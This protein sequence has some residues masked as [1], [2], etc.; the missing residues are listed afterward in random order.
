MKLQALKILVVTMGL[1]IFIGLGFLAYGLAAK[2]GGAS[3]GG[4]SPLQAPLNVTLP[5]GAEVTETVLGENRLLVR[6]TLPDG[7]TRLMVFN[8]EDG[9][10]T[11]IINL[12][13]T[14]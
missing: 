14:P 8:L 7:S 3:G 6:L 12:Q 1:L 2:F 9:R 11:G 10:Q 5:K 13:R 4:V